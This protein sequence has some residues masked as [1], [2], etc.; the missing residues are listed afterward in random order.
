MIWLLSWSMPGQNILFWIAISIA[1]AA[2]DNHNGVQ[3]LLGN[4]LSTFFIK[5]KPDFW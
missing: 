2:T 5:S 1:D 4:V 3:T